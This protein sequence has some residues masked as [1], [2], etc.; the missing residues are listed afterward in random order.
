MAEGGMFGIECQ[1][2]LQASDELAFGGEM[3]GVEADMG[4]QSSSMG[5][6][7]FGC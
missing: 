7:V 4:S 2:C 6:S 3:G 1:L 5:E